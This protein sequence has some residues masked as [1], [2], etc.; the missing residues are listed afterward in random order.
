MKDCKHVAWLYQ[1]LPM[2]VNQGVVPARRRAS[3]SS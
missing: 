3:A 2:L 1:K